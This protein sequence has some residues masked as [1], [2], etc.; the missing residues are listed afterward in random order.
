[1]SIE[2]LVAMI[3]VAC[4]ARYLP[5]KCIAEHIK[6]ENTITNC[7]LDCFDHFNN[8]MV[9]MNGVIKAENWKECKAKW[10]NK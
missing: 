3:S 10:E 6:D 5:A 2:I 4:N 9:G 8:C 1:M 7:R